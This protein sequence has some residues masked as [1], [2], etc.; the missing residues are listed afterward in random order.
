MYNS[1]SDSD[2][3]DD[4]VYDADS[5]RRFMR[6]T[7]AEK[8][9][10]FLLNAIKTGAGLPGYQFN[11]NVQ[12]E[13][14]WVNTTQSGQL[15]QDII[16]LG[17]ITWNAQECNA[18]EI[19]AKRTPYQLREKVL[20]W[21]CRA[22]LLLSCPKAMGPML[23]RE[24]TRRGFRCIIFVQALLTREVKSVGNELFEY[25]DRQETPLVKLD[26]ITPLRSDF[27]G[28]IVPKE[29]YVLRHLGVSLVGDIDEYGNM[30]LKNDLME[31]F[32]EM[33]I[34]DTIFNRPMSHSSG[35]LTILK[36]IITKILQ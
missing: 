30:A 25:S 26:Y 5:Y 9:R 35:L 18:D 31:N 24:L 22:S 13:H 6:A 21:N 19:F 7:N 4:I 8:Y 15:L 36:K 23:L 12:S 2:D 29:Y 33:E 10:K 14:A 1:D 34:Q 27:F 11:T 32:F 28:E 16:G 3:D 20:G 17:L